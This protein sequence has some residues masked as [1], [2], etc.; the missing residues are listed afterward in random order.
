VNHASGKLLNY[1][2][3]YEKNKNRKLVEFSLQISKE[4]MLKLQQ[5]I[6]TFSPTRTV[7]FPVD[8]EAG[9]AALKIAPKHWNNSSCI[10][11][12]VCCL[13]VGSTFA[14]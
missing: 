1:L 6:V 3:I 13:H 7:S 2:V 12:T 10:T 9:V 4:S 11:Q 14:H 5:D 8:L